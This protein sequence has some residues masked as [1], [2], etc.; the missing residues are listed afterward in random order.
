MPREAHAAH[1]KLRA[2]VA[3]SLVPAFLLTAGVSSSSTAKA[4]AQP[5]P[6]SIGAPRI[7]GKA[8]VG[9][10]LQAGRGRWSGN[11]AAVYTFQWRVCDERNT[12]LDVPSASDRIY[13]VRPSDLGHRLLVVVTASTSAGKASA[14]SAP[15]STVLAAVPDS[16]LVAVRPAI[17]GDPEVGATLTAQMGTWRGVGPMSFRY[18]WRRCT[19]DGGAC[20]D[21]GRTTQNYEPTTRD[22]GHTLR[23]LVSARNTVGTSAALA[24]PTKVVVGTT[25]APVAVPTNSSPPAISGVAAQGKTLTASSGTWSGKP[26]LRFSFE[27][28]RC[29]RDGEHC[30]TVTRGTSQAYTLVRADVGSTIRVRVTAR[31]AAGSGSA[32]SDHTPVVVGASAPVNTSPPVIS[33]T[34]QEGNVLTVSPGAWRGTA[35]IGFRYQWLR[36]SASGGRCG[37][38]SGATTTSRVLTSADVGHAL[39]VGVTATNSS[40]SASVLSGPSALVVSR[41]I[42]PANTRAPLLSGTALQGERLSLSSGS[43][44]GTQPFTFS[45]RWMRCSAALNDCR[46]INGATGSTYVLTRADVGSRLFGV[47]TAR[48]RAGS[49]SASSNATPVV[50]GAPVNGSLPTITGKPVEGETL[51]AAPG[52]WAGVT[53]IGFGY[54]WTRCAASGAF[55]TCTPIL[56]TAQPTYTLRLADV[57]HRIFV[58]VKAQNRYGASYVNSTLTDLVAPAPVGTITIRAAQNLAPYGRPVRL[59]GRAVGA[60]AGESVSIIEQPVRGSARVRENVAAVNNAGAWTYV[61]HPTIGTTYTARVRDKTSGGITVLVR[62]RVHLKRLAPGK[63]SVQVVAARSVARRIVFLQRWNPTRHRWL[64]AKRFRLQVARA[65]VPPTVVSVATAHTRLPR[66]T[67]VRVVLT[68]RQAGVGYLSGTS[69]IVRT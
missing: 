69:N 60:P 62:P 61:A 21:L 30:R 26:P 66:G 6:V 37:A 24:D 15:T 31:N 55:S 58:Q 9:Q 59:T 23:V 38:I 12:C 49:S 8:Q 65:G 63:L 36:C 54:Q 28:R 19:V 57:G 52:T 53:P 33:G 45:Y 43:W 51:R 5:P 47:V 67:R 17:A 3:A 56:V 7:E 2:L 46:A 68:S 64:N 34:A 11:R 29:Q 10:I 13:P 44:T 50:V 1:V 22:T 14:Q 18:R 20:M 48:N 16:P 42:A 35:P 25:Q 27:W 40:G 4:T 32:L 39:R 41:G